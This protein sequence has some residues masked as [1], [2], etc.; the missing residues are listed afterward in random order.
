MESPDTICT[1]WFGTATAEATV[2]AQ[3]SALW[4]SKRDETD[5]AI[6]QRFAALVE[7]AADGGLDHWLGT[8]HG[9]L[10][11]ILLTDQFPRNIWRDEARAFAYDALALG[12]SKDAI[13]QGLDQAF[14]P[15]ERVFLYLPLEHAENRADQAEAVR[16]FATLA[17]QV[18]PD[19]QTAFDGFLDYAR[20]HQAIID[21]F[22]R[23]PHR[24]A[25]LGRPS[26]AAETAFLRQPGSGF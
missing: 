11:M 12:W 17:G 3:Q 15:I 8:P 9:R 4:W 25:I 6:R 22:G 10:A 1:F 26:S 20:R 5:A 24:N 14:R 7:R 19:L 2:I 21:R 16:L 13:R 23:F 18:G